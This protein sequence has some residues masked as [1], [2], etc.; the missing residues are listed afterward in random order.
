[1]MSCLDDFGMW[2]QDHL[3]AGLAT[4]RGQCFGIRQA[5]REF[6]ALKEAGRPVPVVPVQEGSP[7]EDRPVLRLRV[8]AGQ[9]AARRQI[10]GELEERPAR[11]L[12]HTDHG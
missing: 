1:M 12:Q 5:V 3:H 7:V 2:N 9:A 6:H 10:D 8:R 11:R 4:E